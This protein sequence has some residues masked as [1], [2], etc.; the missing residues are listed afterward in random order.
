MISLPCKRE[1]RQYANTSASIKAECPSWPI[2]ARGQMLAA[3]REKNK[4]EIKHGKEDERHT[5]ACLSEI[6]LVKERNLSQ[7]VTKSTRTKKRSTCYYLFHSHERDTYSSTFSGVYV[8][9]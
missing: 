4:S 1:P 3:I 2:P 6:Q 9:N 8:S 5:T 7:K